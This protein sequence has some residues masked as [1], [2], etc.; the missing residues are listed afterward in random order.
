MLQTKISVKYTLP[1]DLSLNQF[2]SL[3]LLGEERCVTTKAT[4]KG[5]FTWSW[6]PQVGE[7]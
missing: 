2:L 4:T 5:L 3:S 7:V 6:G 1:F